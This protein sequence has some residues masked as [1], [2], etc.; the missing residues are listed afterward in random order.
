MHLIVLRSQ[1]GT[2]FAVKTAYVH[3]T[4]DTVCSDTSKFQGQQ[5]IHKEFI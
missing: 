4:S 1:Y 2:V 5:S 3:Y